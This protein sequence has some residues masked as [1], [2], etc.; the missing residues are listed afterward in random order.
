[1]RNNETPVQARQRDRTL[2]LF[3]LDRSQECSAQ[4]FSRRSPIAAMRG[5]TPSL[6]YWSSAIGALPLSIQRRYSQRNLIGI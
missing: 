4:P 3:F 2:H 6:R 1:M 5:R